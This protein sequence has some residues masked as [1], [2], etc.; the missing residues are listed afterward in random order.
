MKENN[1]VLVSIINWNNNQAT[2]ACLKSIGRIPKDM[3]P[4]IL[5]IDNYSVREPVNIP[6]TV[7]DSLRSYT[8]VQNEE[9]LGFAGAHNNSL[10]YV[11]ENKY[12]YV[13]LLN[14]DTEIIDQEIFRKLC[15][16]LEGS[17]EAIAAAPTILSD[18][19]G[20]IWYAGGK[21]SRFTG[22]TS[23][24]KVGETYSPDQE[25]GVNPVSFLSGCCIGIKVSS[26]KDFDTYLDDSYFMYWEDADWSA[27]A[28]KAGY[29]LL[30]VAEATILHNTSSSLGFATPTYIYYIIRGNIVFVRRNISFAMKPFS[31]SRISIVS[32]KYLIKSV[33]NPSGIQP[34]MKAVWYGWYDAVIR[35]TGK[36]ARSL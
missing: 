26:L 12:D 11:I 20:T 28:A 5:L 16:A 10:E 19:K 34:V 21:I 24:F 3:Q 30:H 9:N 15:A 1:K 25:R 2:A 14:N 31:Y 8:F 27:Q 29:S 18:Q 7:T 33:K 22:S 23:H 17:P 32:L 4:D 13:F 35:K 6:K 36:L